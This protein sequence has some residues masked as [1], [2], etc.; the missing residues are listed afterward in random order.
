MGIGKRHYELLAVTGGYVGPVRG[1]V[2]LPLTD[3]VQALYGRNGVGKTQVLRIVESAVTGRAIFDPSFRDPVEQFRYLPGISFAHLH[4]RLARGGEHDYKSSPLL[5]AI[6]DGAK[7]L[8]QATM[9]KKAEESREDSEPHDSYAHLRPRS[10]VDLIENLLAQIFSADGD[11]EIFDRLAEIA[12]QGRFTLVPV[13][14]VDIPR[15]R[16]WLGY[17]PTSE[18]VDRVQ[19]MVKSPSEIPEV[20]LDDEDWYPAN[21]AEPILGRPPRS[22]SNSAYDGAV[23]AITDYVGDSDGVP[24]PAWWQVPA[25]DLGFEIR[26]P[27]ADLVGGTHDRDWIGGRETLESAL[28]TVRAESRNRNIGLTGDVGELNEAVAGEIDRVRERANDTLRQIFDPAPRLMFRVG[29]PA[30][31]IIGEVPSW[32]HDH[33]ALDGPLYEL[34]SLSSAELRWVRIALGVAEMRFSDRPTVVLCDEPEQGLHLSAERRLPEALTY[35]AQRDEVAVLVATHSHYTLVNP[36]VSVIRAER[37]EERG[38]SLN[39]NN[40]LSILSAAARRRS[41]HELSLE[42]PEL[43]ALMKVAVVVEGLHDEIVFSNLLHDEFNS[44]VAGIFPMHSGAKASSLAEARLMIDGS[45]APILVI[46]DNI[47]HTDVEP[48]WTDTVEKFDSGDLDGARNFVLENFPA[49][50]SSE[51]GYLRQL[52]IAAIEAGNLRRI[53]IY[54]LSR[55]DVVCY[56]PEDLIL[57]PGKKKAHWTWDRFIQAFHDDEQVRK[58]NLGDKFKPRS[59]K[60]FLNSNGWLP[61]EK[62]LPKAIEDAAVAA[63]IAGRLL[64]N[65]LDRLAAKVLEL[66]DVCDRRK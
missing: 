62:D 1:I 2:H 60:T 43:Q 57:T 17:H 20:D 12:K 59:I 55:P 66:S 25:Y 31:W 63:R 53:K 15:W 28:Q 32:V 6:A 35:I 7:G 29:G 19:E 38:T 42:A 22:D 11:N 30:N 24:L 10:L 3:G 52:A 44:A 16:V 56:L 36:K 51:L 54:G 65:D 50:K 14:T 4:F 49:S 41:E 9:G 26:V 13:G 34:T 48:I 5:R 61:Y 23:R 39:P 21:A 18:E 27:A 45:N 64:H 58:A 40:T 46:L 8:A 37:S 33:G 47:A